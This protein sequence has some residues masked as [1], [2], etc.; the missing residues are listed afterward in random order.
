MAPPNRVFTSKA[1]ARAWGLGMR[2]ALDATIRLDL[3]RAIAT[4][5]LAMP[6]YQRAHT[7]LTYVGVKSGELDT[8]A[9][10]EAAWAGGK[11]VLVPLTRPGGGMEW[12]RL[13]GMADLMRTPRGLLEPRPDALR[14][15][16]PADGLCI[17][18]G[19]CFR[20]DGHR[21]GFGGGYFDRFLA[22]FGG[23]TVALAPEALFGVEFPV[24]N[25]DQ[26]VAV[27]VTETAT[28]RIAAISG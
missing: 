27:V 3:G 7:L 1:D 24:E 12:S 10:I 2:A 20:S 19:V 11:A 5:L 8:M 16:D 18:P 15:V 13:D 9:L 4:R 17:V 14:P 6:E 21:I 25:H 26:P 28:H 22:G 23:S